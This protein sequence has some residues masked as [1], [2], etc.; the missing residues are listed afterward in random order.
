MNQGVMDGH[1]VEF[2]PR[3]Q[4]VLMACPSFG[5]LVRDRRSAYSG[6]GGQP[7]PLDQN[8]LLRQ[9]DCPGC[10]RPMDVHPY[11]GP[12]GIVIDSC[13]RCQIVWLDCNEISRI[14]AAPGLR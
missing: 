9:V 8:D 5:R 1:P 7:R 14:E 6:S 11:Y 3:C 10:H 4:G 2:C 12:G 13:H